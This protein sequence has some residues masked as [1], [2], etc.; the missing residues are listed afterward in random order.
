MLYIVQGKRYCRGK[1]LEKREETNK[2]LKKFHARRAF[3]IRT[4]IQI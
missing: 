1:Y 4:I 2:R 3:I